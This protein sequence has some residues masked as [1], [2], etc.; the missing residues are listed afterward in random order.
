M[1]KIFFTLLIAVSLASCNEWLDINRDPNQPSEVAPELLLAQSELALATTYGGVLHNQGSFIVQYF[2]NRVGASNFKPYNQFDVQANNGNLQWTNLYN[3]CMVNA[4][5]V[6]TKTAQTQDWGNYLAATVI[7]GFAA[8]CIIDNFGEAPYS[9]ALGGGAN[10]KP[11]Y[12]EGA[13]VYAAVLAELDYALAHIGT[14]QVTKSNL[15]FGANST[16]KWIQ[17]ANALKLRLLM[18][19]A[20]KDWDS[21]KDLVNALITENNFPATDVSYKIYADEGTKR[22]PWYMDAY[23]FFGQA[24]H[25][26]SAAYINTLA[27]KSDPRLSARFDLP[28]NPENA[29][30]HKGG[31][32][33]FEY[34]TTTDPKEKFSTPKYNAVAPVYLITVSE[35]EFF[36]AEAAL[37]T[38]GVAAAKTAY[39]AAI[40]ASFA[41]AGVTGAS[42]FLASG[43]DYA[44][45][46]TQSVDDGLKQIALQKWI[47]LGTINGFESWCELRR[48]GV[49]FCTQTATDIQADETKY[50]Y[51]KL[52]YPI[53]APG[54]LSATKTLLNRYYYP[55]ISTTVNQNAPAQKTPATK[56][57]WQN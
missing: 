44:W 19:Q 1:K 26:G 2:V 47:A 41:Q 32:P 27:A 43:G 29:T 18:R 28:T 3:L 22:N 6:R 54:I 57:F 25:M 36:K 24:D 8:Q 5:E 48:L 16:E 39:D 52:I 7:K 42:A 45:S 56:I 33:G 14:S 17:F 34:I 51:G 46:T 35:I 21:V 11:A 53:G 10:A 31:V 49:S 4:E 23:I 13:T 40:T 37:R 38:S 15:L 30:F 9:Q 20:A 55:T 50:E 12:D